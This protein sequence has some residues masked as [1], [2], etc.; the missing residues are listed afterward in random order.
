MSR[1]HAWVPDVFR[2]R[3]TGRIDHRGVFGVH[4]SPSGRPPFRPLKRSG[5]H[6]FRG[7]LIDHS[8]VKPPAVPPHFVEAPS[9][10]RE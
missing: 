10:T 4:P 5:T 8:G 2:R 6:A 3:N 7:S 9:I 1:P